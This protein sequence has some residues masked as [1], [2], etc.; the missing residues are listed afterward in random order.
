[1]DLW[2]AEIKRPGTDAST[3]R[4]IIKAESLIGENKTIKPLG[5]GLYEYRG[6]QSKRGTIRLYFCFDET[7]VYIL[8]AEFK[9]DDQHEIERAR[10]R[11][12]EMG[13]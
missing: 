1:M 5:N 4:E 11:K 13:V 3:L 7:T 6:K 10:K 9:T 8:D 2:L 12:K